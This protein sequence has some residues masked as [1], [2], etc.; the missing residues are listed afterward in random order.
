MNG[1]EPT[2][3]CRKGLFIF[4]EMS[5]SLTEGSDSSIFLDCSLDKHEGNFIHFPFV[6]LLQNYIIIAI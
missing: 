4:Y 5:Q 1:A 3:C 2:G 6:V